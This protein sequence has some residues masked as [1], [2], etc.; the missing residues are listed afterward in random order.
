MAYLVMRHEKY[1]SKDSI[2][3]IQDEV[4]REA[5]EYNNSVDPTKRSENVSLIHC[6]DF[7]KKIDEII[8]KNGVS[9]NEDSVK[10]IGSIYS[11]SPEFFEG[12]T[13][14]EIVE[15]Y[16]DCLEFHKEHYGEVISAEIHF[17]E[18]TPHLHVYSVPV[19]E[20]PTME[21][22]YVKVD[23]NGKATKEEISKNDPDFSSTEKKRKQRYARDENGDI[24]THKGLNGARAL[25]GKGQLSNHQD[26]IVAKVGVKYGL[27]RGEVRVG[28]EERRK[29]KN[30]MAWKLEKQQ[31]Q[32]E[33]QQATIEQQRAEL[34]RLADRLGAEKLK[35]DEIDVLNQKARENASESEK[36]L[37]TALN[38]SERVEEIPV[39]VQRYFQE[40]PEA[41][42][43]YQEW[44]TQ[45]K[46][47]AEA[48]REAERK[49]GAE[50]IKKVM[51]EAQTVDD[52][53]RGL[54]YNA[55]DFM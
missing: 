53:K 4:N 22:Y 11:A 41:K 8:K 42:S 28:T 34:N 24:I 46:R 15:Y 7:E 39:P 5:D 29:H 49:K 27:E 14:D 17:D 48:K 20:V 35:F 36:L 52:A 6:E 50:E 47:E 43:Q 25:G 10:L 32:I 33:Q 23:E 44:V 45:K 37:K 3:G 38:V 40:V 13:K 54:G 31:K 1:N 26:E 30:A 16:N 2:K 9:C 51:D 55:M 21:N 18:T 12:K 19:I